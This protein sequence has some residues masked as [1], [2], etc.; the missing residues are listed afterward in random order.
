M[1]SSTPAAEVVNLRKSYR[2]HG[3]SEP[4]RAVDGI[5]FTVPRGQIIG[6]LGPT[7]AGKTTTIKSLCGL[8]RPDEGEL[9]V[10]GIDVRRHRSQALRHLSAVLEGNRNLYWRLTPLENVIYFGG[11]RGVPARRAPDAGGVVHHHR[12]MEQIPCVDG[13]VGEVDPD[14]CQD[15][16]IPCPC[17]ARRRGVARGAN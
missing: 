14:R 13:R 4:F 9:R 6:L 17:Y 2:R 16:F 10:S 3:S 8:I 7:G 11:N 15:L 12:E 5:S 1:S